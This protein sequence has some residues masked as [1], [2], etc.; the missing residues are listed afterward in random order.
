[1]FETK[2]KNEFHQK[3]IDFRFLC[4]KL[5]RDAE[6]PVGSEAK[7]TFSSDWKSK[8]REEDI[9]KIEYIGK[10]VVKL[11]LHS[12]QY[13]NQRKHSFIKLA[14]LV[15]VHLADDNKFI[16]LNKIMQNRGGSSEKVKSIGFLAASTL[17]SPLCS[18]SE[19]FEEAGL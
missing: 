19:Y 8:L 18:V 5:R 9:L 6:Q 1:M 11:Y 2:L 15:P 14:L 10:C 12:Q 13:I 3:S 17:C 16:V 7:T 4:S